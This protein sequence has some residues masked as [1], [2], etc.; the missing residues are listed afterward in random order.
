MDGGEAGDGAGGGVTGGSGRIAGGD[1]ISVR[2]MRLL[3]GQEQL[4]S[5]TE[6]GKRLISFLIMLD[7][8]C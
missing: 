2:L 4:F 7:L 8:P 1:K 6:D 3:I 5:M